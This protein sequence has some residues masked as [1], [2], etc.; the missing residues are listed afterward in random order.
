MRAATSILGGVALLLCACG[1][2]EASVFAF[3]RS[4]E[5]HVDRSHLGDLADLKVTAEFYVRHDDRVVLHGGWLAGD[6]GAFV[7]QLGLALPK[8]GD[9]LVNQWVSNGSLVGLCDLQ[10]DVG[11][12]VSGVQDR[13]RTMSPGFPVKIRCD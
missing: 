7:A 11:V 9:Q 8:V 4:A 12:T 13:V 1:E 5:V 6:D 10:L 3:V 2:R